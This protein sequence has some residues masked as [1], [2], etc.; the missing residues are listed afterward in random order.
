M[1]LLTKRLAVDTISESGETFNADLVVSFTVI[2]KGASDCEIGYQGEAPLMR[3]E[4]GTSVEFPGDSGY[5]WDGEWVIRFIGSN[6]GNIQ[7]R[8]AI[9]RTNES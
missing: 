5:T 6:T 2:N 1:R 4:K 7:V 8:K 9:A 3:I